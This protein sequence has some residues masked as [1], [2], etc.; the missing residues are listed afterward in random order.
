MLQS[1]WKGKHPIDLSSPR[2]RLIRGFQIL[3]LLGIWDLMVR[4]PVELTSYFCKTLKVP[5]AQRAKNSIKP[6]VE[7]KGM[8]GE[9]VCVWEQLREGLTQSAPFHWVLCHFV[10]LSE[11]EI[12][13]ASPPRC[14]WE[15]TAGMDVSVFSRWSYGAGVK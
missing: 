11:W 12:V 15:T 14:G 9:T 10:F 2:E 13:C 6:V 4:A 5:F 1:P 8:H 3:H 7:G